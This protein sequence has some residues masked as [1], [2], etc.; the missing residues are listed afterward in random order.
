MFFRLNY[1]LT[2]FQHG[3]NDFCHAN[4]PRMGSYVVYFVQERLNASVKDVERKC[5]DHVCQLDDAVGMYYT[6]DSI[7]AHELRAV[8]Q[9][10]AF[11][12]LQMDVIPLMFFVDV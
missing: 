9:G 4:L 8:Q 3:V 2:A 12:R 5:A 1:K 6:P 10:K 11:F 7:G